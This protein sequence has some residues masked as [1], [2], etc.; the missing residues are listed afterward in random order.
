VADLTAMIVRW[1]RRGWTAGTPPRG[2]AARTFQTT[3][4]HH[5]R[6]SSVLISSGR[7][8]IQLP[9]D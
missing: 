4:S 7:A 3:P 8:E 2:P 5:H 1:W 9:Q 6:G